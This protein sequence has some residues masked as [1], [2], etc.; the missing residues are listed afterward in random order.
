[1]MF[2]LISYIPFYIQT[3]ELQQYHVYISMGLKGVCILLFFFIL[4][5]EKYNGRDIFIIVCL[6]LFAIISKN[7]L[8]ILVGLILISTKEMS[9]R[10]VVE[11]YFYINLLLILSVLL[12]YYMGFL[13]DVELVKHYEKSTGHLRKTLGFINP[14][15]FFVKMIPLI[16]SYVYLKYENWNFKN[17]LI[18]IIV[19]FIGFLVTGSRTGTFANLLLL[20]YIYCFKCFNNLIFNQIFL[21]IIFKINFFVL[22]WIT[23][24]LAHIDNENNI[25][26]IVLSRRPLY[27]SKFIEEGVFSL[28]FFFG[29]K[30]IEMLA[31]YPLDNGYLA[32]LIYGGLLS[33]L[34]FNHIYMKGITQIIEERKAK[35]I[36][37]IL[38]ISIYSLF[39]DVLLNILLNFSWIILY[40]RIGTNTEGEDENDEQ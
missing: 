16:M 6:F 12:L 40:K 15:T 24:L 22:T 27:W 29:R 39:E 5:F 38:Y 1:M 11:R 14:N 19:I 35:I 17:T 18:L 34:F 28:L 4:I 36:I 21:R 2:T 32:I 31:K 33:F 10:I 3:Y 26:N 7:M 8:F 25:L 13:P 20:I 37:I 23:I 30:K 9:E